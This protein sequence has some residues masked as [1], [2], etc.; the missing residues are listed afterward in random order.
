MQSSIFIFTGLLIFRMDTINAES[1]K[2]IIGRDFMFDHSITGK[3][4]PPEQ[5]IECVYIVAEKERENKI[6]N[7]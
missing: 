2:E 5:L 3:K 7:T 1:R 4:T 6:C